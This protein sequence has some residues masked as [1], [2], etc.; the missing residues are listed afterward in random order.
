M[1]IYFYVAKILLNFLS[2]KSILELLNIDQNLEFVN[3][4]Y[5]IVFLDVHSLD[6][7]Y[8]TIISSINSL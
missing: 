4:R 6:K 8:L 5:D 2:M 3:Y 1:A 7:S